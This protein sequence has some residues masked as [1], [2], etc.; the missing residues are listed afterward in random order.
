MARHAAIALLLTA[1]ALTGCGRG[2]FF[3]RWLGQL[4][5]GEASVPC[6][7][8][9]RCVA[10]RGGVVRRDDGRLVVTWVGHATALVQMDDRFILT[11]PVFTSSVGQLSR[12]LVAPGLSPKQVPPVDAVLISHMHFDHLSLGSLEQL[13][14]KVRRLFVAPG[15]LVYLTNFAFDARELAPW[16]TSAVSA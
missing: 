5:H 11:D 4:G 12:R 7:D 8:A 9:Q 16:Q 3:S 6:F 14:P 15:G 2:R 10:A 1:T 13:E